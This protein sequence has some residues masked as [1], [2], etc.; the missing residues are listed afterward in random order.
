MRIAS[1]MRFLSLPPVTNCYVSVAGGF[2]L[3]FLGIVNWG[4]LGLDNSNNYA[5]DYL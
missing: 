1:A 5:H 4:I 2:R 3:I